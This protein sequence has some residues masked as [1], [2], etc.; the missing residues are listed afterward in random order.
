MH[1]DAIERSL[2]LAVQQASS[3][4]NSRG[5]ERNIFILTFV[6]TRI[7][8]VEAIISVV[9]VTVKNAG[10]RRRRGVFEDVLFLLYSS[11]PFQ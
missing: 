3:R 5:K 1:L 10:E 8:S 2:D 6:Q 11:P 7:Q 9:Q 4:P